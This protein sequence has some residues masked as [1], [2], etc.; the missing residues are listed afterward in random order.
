MKRGEGGYFWLPRPR[1]R[2]GG[3]RGPWVPVD[4]AAVAE[5]A[6]VGITDELKG[7]AIAGFVILKEKKRSSSG[8]DLLDEFR[9]H[10]AKKIGADNSF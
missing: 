4:H 2:R 6:F 8:H 7:T 3:R 9:G 5:S 10:V 1:R